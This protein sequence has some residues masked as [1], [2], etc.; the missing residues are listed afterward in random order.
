MNNASPSANSANADCRSEAL[1]AARSRTV[2]PERAR[3]WREREQRLF[4]RVGQR[5]EG[6]R[7]LAGMRL[8]VLSVRAP[9]VTVE[10]SLSDAERAHLRVVVDGHRARGRD[11]IASL[12]ER[13]LSPRRD[14][15]MESWIRSKVRDGELVDVSS[16]CLE[17]C[18]G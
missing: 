7:D 10:A 13:K 15:R 17:A 2:S 6:R 8:R 14:V 16:E 18:R 9:F 5:F 3:T 11:A 1:V 12:L 4:L